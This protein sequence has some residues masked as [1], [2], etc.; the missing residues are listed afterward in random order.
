[1]TSGVHS[2]EP[3]DTEIGRLPEK[4]RRFFLSRGVR[5]EDDARDL[6]QETLLRVLQRL[7]RGELLD[8]PEAFSLGVAKNVFFEYCR[9]VAKSHAHDG[10]SGAVDL[11][12]GEDPLTEALASSQAVRFRRALELLPERMKSLL[13][14]RF[15]EEVPSRTIA[16]EE[17]ISTDAIDMRVYRAKRELKKRMDHEKAARDGAGPAPDPDSLP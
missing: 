7:S 10:L 13:L 6:A 17:G 16:R 1:V 4:L 3:F 2:S 15:V 14:K 12:G 9:R 5:T 8:S 11:A